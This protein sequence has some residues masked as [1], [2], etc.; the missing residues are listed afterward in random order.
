MTA[1]KLVIVW[2]EDKRTW[3]NFLEE[4]K[5]YASLVACG[6]IVCTFVNAVEHN[7]KVSVFFIQYVNN[8]FIKLILKNK[9]SI[10]F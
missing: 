2:D 3:G 7:C 6:Y 10:S 4:Q 8:T 5:Y 1:N 9:N